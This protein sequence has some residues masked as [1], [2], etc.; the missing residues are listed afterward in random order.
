M[1]EN[2]YNSFSLIDYAN[3]FI[4]RVSIDLFLKLHLTT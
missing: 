2:K 4:F 3:F 1:Y